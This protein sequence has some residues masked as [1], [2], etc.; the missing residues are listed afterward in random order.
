M[1]IIRWKDAN[2]HGL[3]L[4]FTG[5][6]CKRGHLS[7]RSVKGGWCAECHTEDCR[8]KW[9]Q[10]KRP[11]Y[12]QKDS[13]LRR[14]IR[15]N[16]IPP[17]VNWDKIHAVYDECVR[18]SRETGIPHHVDHIIPQRGVSVSGLHVHTNLRVI[19][20]IDNMR[21]RNKIDEELINQSHF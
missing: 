1:E 2:A 5:K 4:Y 16:T 10:A 21:K 8:N 11:E 13:A 12:F 7:K 17:W 9:K 20:A 3:S 18:I 15:T 19:P 6:P 14:A